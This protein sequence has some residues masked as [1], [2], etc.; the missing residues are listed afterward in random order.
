[1]ST[2]PFETEQQSPAVE[3]FLLGRIGFE[4]CL[5]LQR[6]LVEQVG[7]RDDGQIVVLICEHPPII[8]VGRGGSPG[9]VALH[10]RTLRERQIE[11]R[12]VNRGGG[13]MVHCPGQLA[14]Y[15]IVPLRWHEFSVGEYLQRFQAGLMETLDTLNIPGTAPPGRIGVW[16][17]TGQLAAVGVAVRNWVTYYG[18]YLNVSPPMGLF[19][20]V[21][22][23]PDGQTAMSCLLAERRGSARMTAVR[24]TLVG[25]LAEAFGCER[26]HLHTGHPWLRK[27]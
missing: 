10:S 12:W 3:T 20:L 14:V 7:T 17:R 16:G 1:M 21:D 6:R 11:V 2:T 26:Y 25:H 18:A 5:K 22:T 27:E 8:T 13:C 19:R 24:A 23:D 4:R 15:P 9:D